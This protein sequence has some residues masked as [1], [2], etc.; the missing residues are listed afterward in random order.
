MN[1]IVEIIK[2]IAWPVSVIWLG[3]LFR[4]ELRQLLGRMSRFKYGDIE[5]S[6]E[7]GLAEAEKNAEKVPRPVARKEKGETL[8]LQEQLFRIAEVSPRA[9]I[10]E[11]WTLIETAARKAGLTS[12]VAIQR[13]TPKMIMDHLS[14]SGKLSEESLYLIERLRRLRNQAAHMPDFAISQSEAERFL[15]LAVR[16]AAIIEGAVGG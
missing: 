11:A 12:G 2:A 13:T 15:E 7:K 9:A 1:Q 16:S 6:F 10:V 3:Y 4:S 5:A 8:S 14:S